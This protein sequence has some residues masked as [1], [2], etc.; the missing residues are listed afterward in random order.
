MSLRK[1]VM[2]FEGGSWKDGARSWKY[3][4]QMTEDGA[5]PLKLEA[6]SLKHEVRI[7]EMDDR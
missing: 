1:V 5:S 6:R 4:R 2:G 3:A 7:Q